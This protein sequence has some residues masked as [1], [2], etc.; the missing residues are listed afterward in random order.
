VSIYTWPSTLIPN[1]MTLRYLAVNKV[2]RSPLN[3]NMQTASRP[4]S[5]LAFDIVLSTLTNAQRSELQGFLA[6]LD[7]Q[8]NYFTMPYY[9][10][11]NLGALGG[12]PVVNGA[13]Q[14][15]ASIATS[16]WPNNTLVLKRG[17]VVG[18]GTEL[19]I[20]TDDV[21]SDGTGHATLPIRPSQRNAPTNGSAIVTTDPT[22]IFVLEQPNVGVNSISNPDIR[23]GTAAFTVIE[24]VTQ[25]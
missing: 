1:Q 22:G 20:I 21:N 8:L 6:K 13:G 18:I 17:D 24:M 10:H 11:V 15:G 9:G 25:P 16:G 3:G 19:K 2:F 23:M 12:T 4:G 7:G 14:T 5:W